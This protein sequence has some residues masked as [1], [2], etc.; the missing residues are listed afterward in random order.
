MPAPV[1]GEK[2]PTLLC[3]SDVSLHLH[4][5]LV[6][7][8]QWGAALTAWREKKV[9]KTCPVAIIRE[10]NEERYRGDKVNMTRGKF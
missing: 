9:P 4:M 5:R 6:L 8:E 1:R 3:K 7:A 10:G 2:S